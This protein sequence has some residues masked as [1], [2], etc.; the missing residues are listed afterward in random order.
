MNQN[1]VV[2]G[3]SVGDINGVGPEVILKTFRDSRM[4]NYCTPVIFASKNL[5]SYYIKMYNLKEINYHI[6]RNPSRLNPKALNLYCPWQKE[7]DHTIN[8]G[9]STVTGGVYAYKSLESAV[10]ALK[11]G[12]VDVIVTAPINKNNIQ[13]TQFKYPGHTEFLKDVF[14]VNKTLM[15]MV[16][17]QMKVAMVTGHIPVKEIPQHI[18]QDEILT[19]LEILAQT[20]EY[21]F[22]IQKPKIAV[23]ALNPHASDSGL[24][25]DEEANHIIPAI[26]AAK[27]KGILAFG[28][29]PAD[30]FFGNTTYTQYD[31]I[32]AMYHD[33]GLIPFK[34][35]GFE[36]GVNYTAGLPIVRTSPVHGTGYNIA[37]KN[38]ADES[39]F[40]NAIFTALK[41]YSNRKM[42]EEIRK[43][44]LKIHVDREMEDEGN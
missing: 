29:Y 43:N 12:M 39:S 5:I 13:S 44:P 42:Q 8:V 4:Y 14:K 18:N 32:L 36:S 34:L 7:V 40:R 1:K 9:Q 15:I 25:G 16:S 41:I 35:M 33:Q 24:L 28:P 17:D 2:V 6:V 30:G 10:H 27:E 19:S 22:V 38:L 23:L 11:D 26:K 3:I 37:G 21:D 31:A 20:L